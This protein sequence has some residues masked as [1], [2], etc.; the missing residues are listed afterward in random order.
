MRYQRTKILVKNGDEKIENMKILVV[1]VDKKI[2]QMI[3][4]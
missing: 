3:D 4:A 2:K 1:N